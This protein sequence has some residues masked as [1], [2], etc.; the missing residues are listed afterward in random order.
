VSR[1]DDMVAELRREFRTFRLVPKE[2]SPLMRLLYRALLMP[3]WCPDFMGSYTTVLV[4]W[5]YMPARLIGTDQGYGVLR[6]ERVHMRDCFRTGVLPFAVSYVLLLPAV[7]TLRSVW[8]MRGYAE[9]MRVE[10]EQEGRISDELLA[11]VAR[12]FTSSSYLWMCPFPGFVERWVRR[13][14]DRVLAARREPA[15]TA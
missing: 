3:L 6:H 7:L 11:H 2:R 4:S 8:E 9:T 14:R 5:V 10:L 15:G 1:F 13:T 12:Q